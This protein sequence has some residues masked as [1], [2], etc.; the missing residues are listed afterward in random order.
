MLAGLA[1]VAVTAGALFTG[2]DTTPRVHP[3]AGASA[4]D[5]AR[6]YRFTETTADGKAVHW[7]PCLSIHYVV[8]LS[9]APYPGAMADI[10]RAISEVSHWS[11]L[12]FVND[13]VTSMPLRSDRSTKVVRDGTGSAAPMLIGWASRKTSDVLDGSDGL[14]GETEIS[15]GESHSGFIESAIVGLNSDVKDFAPGFGE[16]DHWGTVLLHELG[17]AVGLDHVNTP[18][19]IMS[20]EIQGRN[21]SYGPGDRAGLGAVGAGS[22]AQP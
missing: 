6:G 18:G 2:S 10:E 15:S 4:A 9:E 5:D 1:V 11:R 14:L 8:N 17:H 13:G 7:D 22:C 20:P 19:E 12:H 21:A 16:G 3:A